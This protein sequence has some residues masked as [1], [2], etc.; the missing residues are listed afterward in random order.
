MAHALGIKV[1]TAR[2]I[3][4]D[5]MAYVT[6]RANRKDWDRYAVVIQNWWVFLHLQSYKLI[7]V[8]LFVGAKRETTRWFANRL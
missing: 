6:H 4:I 5:A 7:W 8:H 3:E 1:E 2:A